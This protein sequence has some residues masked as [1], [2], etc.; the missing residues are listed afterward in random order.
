LRVARVRSAASVRGVSSI[1]CA[2]FVEDGCV[3]DGGRMGIV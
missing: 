2:I 1:W 3:A